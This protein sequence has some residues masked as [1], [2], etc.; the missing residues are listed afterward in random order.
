[1]FPKSSESEDDPDEE[2]SAGARF[3]ARLEK[4]RERRLWDQNRTKLLFDYAQ[5]S[6]NAGSVSCN[7]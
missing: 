3:E 1:M 6:Y 5:F 2:G 7:I 4:Q